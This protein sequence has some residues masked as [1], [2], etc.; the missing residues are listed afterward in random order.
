MNYSQ[1]LLEGL[2]DSQ[3][4]YRIERHLAGRVYLALDLFKA[5]LVALKLLRRVACAPENSAFVFEMA[6]HHAIGNDHVVTVK[7]FGLLKSG[8]FFYTMEY[9]EGKTLREEMGNITPDRALSIIK[10][11]CQGLQKAHQ[12]VMPGPWRLGDLPVIIPHGKLHPDHILLLP[13]DWVK[14]LNFGLISEEDG[15]NSS[16]KSSI[17]TLVTS[18]GGELHY[19][20][21]EQL[22][23]VEGDT[24]SDV[25]VLGMLFY[26]ML[27][28]TNPY[29]IQ[30]YNGLPWVMAHAT[31]PPVPLTQRTG[32]HHF[33]AGL[34]HITLKCLSK[35]PAQRYG[36]AL[37]LLSDLEA[38]HDLT[39]EREDSPTQPHIFEPT[40]L[41]IPEPDGTQTIALTV[42]P[43]PD[44]TSPSVPLQEALT[45]P[46]RSPQSILPTVAENVTELGDAFTIAESF[47]NYSTFI[48]PDA[49]Q[50]K[51]PLLLIGI[52]LAVVV[53][54]SIF[55][56]FVLWKRNSSP[57]QDR[58]PQ[59]I[60]RSI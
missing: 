52:T 55:T 27:T 2:V 14:L 26:E 51:I 37:E 15:K 48:E 36:N 12:G 18:I 8:D 44:E 23:K 57:P 16:E 4:R 22:E 30:T 33:P 38:V 59:P 6:L 56:A 13:G 34:E 35:D 47:N 45:V 42:Q 24:R 39:A 53:N 60:D 32:C 29:G 25:Y 43:S 40:S 41:I 58:Q 7:D 46:D 1:N 31:M 50:K 49:K 19:I 9:I 11:I 17:S 5:E 20:A 28:G 3:D 21:P 54:L 10:Q